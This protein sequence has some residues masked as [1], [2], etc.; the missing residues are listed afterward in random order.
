MKKILRSIFIIFGL[1][2][3]VGIATP[4]MV[5]AQSAKEQVCDGIGASAG[6]GGCTEGSGKS[7]NDIMALVINIFSWV[8]GAVAVI[9]AI[10]AG[11][12]YITSGGDPSAVKSAKDTLLYVVI[13]LVI[14]ALSQIIVN[15]V[16]RK[17]NNLVTYNYSSIVTNIN[18]NKLV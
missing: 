13:G 6:S 5:T 9:F 18:E 11:F 4:V 14:V 8:V 15:F 1:L 16:L 10:V 2:F 17:S 3:I 12:K 7:L